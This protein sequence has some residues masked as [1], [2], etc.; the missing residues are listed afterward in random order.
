MTRPLISQEYYEQIVNK[1]KKYNSYDSNPTFEF[2]I[3]RIAHDGFVL[4]YT[5][6]TTQ[7]QFEQIFWYTTFDERPLPTQISLTLGFY[8][9]NKRR[10]RALYDLYP[11][12]KEKTWEFNTGYRN[13][14]GDFTEHMNFSTDLTEQEFH[15]DVQLR[16]TPW[17]LIVSVDTIIPKEQTDSV[18]KHTELQL[19]FSNYPILTDIGHLVFEEA[20]EELVFNVLTRDLTYQF[21]KHFGNKL[22]DY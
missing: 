6:T 19:Y 22:L 12:L 3:E 13:K 20:V 9:I 8:D 17:E 14:N 2:H 15:N 4:V 18:I 5:D 10:I 1:F 7:F 16:I 21:K 11:E